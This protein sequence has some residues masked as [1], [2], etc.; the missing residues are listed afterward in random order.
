MIQAP[1]T[2]YIPVQQP[3]MTNYPS[4]GA[5]TSA[6]SYN[7]QAQGT[8]YNYPTASCYGQAQPNANAKSQY[9]GVNIEI[10]NPQGQG[11]VPQNGVTMPAQYVPVQQPIA[12]PVYP[13]YPAAQ[14]IVQAPQ[15]PQAPVVDQPQA[16]IPQV[17]APQ[18][19]TPE[20]PQAA[21][22][23]VNQPVATPD[24]TQTPESFAGKLKTDDLEAQ[25]AAI[26]E[27]AEA[28]KNNETLG[29]V[30]LD[31]Q[32]FDALVDIIDKD[33][34]SLQGPTPEIIELRQKPQ[35]ELS[36]EEKAKA[37]TPTPLEAAEINKQYALYTISFM[38][39]RL[40]NELVKR[41]GQALE[42][43]DLPCIEKVIDTVKSNQNPI[44][45]VGAIYA[46]SHIQ[47]PEYKADLNT[48]FELAKS[49]EDT[50]V[51]EAAN[52]AIESLNQQAA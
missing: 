32:I 22:P 33:T 23:V 15:Y 38:Q 16:Q 1:N 9:N 31:T 20:Q 45:R 8:I 27:V 46:L 44:L 43:K 3:I 18:V 41:N 37:T 12:M 2:Q 49:D 28:V 50:R 26:E 30:L 21:A 7:P 13:N 6:V 35:E 17:P 42:L 25:K 11:F 47:R 4:T 40:N 14:T 39:E 36:E 34:S 10:I 52:K 51:Q 48:I 29:P 19:Q 5:T 24:A